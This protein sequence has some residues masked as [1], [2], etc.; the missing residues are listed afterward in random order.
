MDNLNF[1]CEIWPYVSPPLP[2]PSPQAAA[3]SSHASTREVVE[4]LLPASITWM[5][6]WGRGYN[7]MR[8]MDVR[9]GISK[10]DDKYGS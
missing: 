9:E 2:T 7:L 5:H 10:D 3:A 6:R 4:C 8:W 1:V